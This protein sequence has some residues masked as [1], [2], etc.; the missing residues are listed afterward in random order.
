MYDTCPTV[1]V[2]SGDDFA[3]INESDFDPAVHERFEDA[4][5]PPPPVPLPPLPPGVVNPLDNLGA[6][7]KKRDDLKALAAAV[8]GGRAVEN[9]AQAIEVIEAALAARR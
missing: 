1:K 7:W 9:K 5:P 6:D 8:S 2:K 3:I 4:P